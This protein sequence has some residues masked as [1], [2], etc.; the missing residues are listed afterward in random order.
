M[1]T[2]ISMFALFFLFQ[3]AFGVS[4]ISEKARKLHTKALVCDLHSDTVLKLKK[5]DFILGEKN[6]KGHI[7]IPRLKEGGVD[8][9][10]F[11][12]WVAPEFLPD[13]AAREALNLIDLFYQQL[14]KYPDDLELAKNISDFKKINKKGRIAC[15]LGLEGGHSI[16]GDISLLR[17]FHRLGVKYMTLTWENSNLLAS[18]ASDTSTQK[19]GLTEL[20]KEVIKEM[21]RLGM[22]VDGS[23]LF[24][25]AFWEVMELSNAPVI[26][27]HSCVRAICNHYRN[28]NDEQIKAIAKSG[29]VIGINFFSGYLDDDFRKTSDSI[30]KEIQIKKEEI[31]EKFKGDE[32][33]IEE[34]TEL[35]YSNA[36]FPPPTSLS[37]LVDHIDYIAKLV[38][39]DY[40]A[41][42]SDFDGIPAIPLE[43]KDCSGL[44]KIT[45]ELLKR[46]YKDKD[47]KK[48]LGG[49]FLRVFKKVCR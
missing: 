29:G 7:D 25:Q 45:Q 48:I 47:I 44:P 18:S 1:K 22:I 46:G 8:L 12:I 40:V 39:P 28:L 34:E 10:V 3:M 32:K 2:I 19:G 30:Y 21:N 24:E 16:E 31:K 13:S 42:G 6:S 9:Q 11:A 17:T 15:V 49:N 26:A 38:G 23:H 27:S 35:L 4:D 33:K 5:G 14:E 20:G 43:I 41:L 37:K 36:N